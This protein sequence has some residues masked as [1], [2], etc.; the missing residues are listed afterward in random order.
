MYK[1]D[2]LLIMFSCLNIDM[3]FNERYNY[4]EENF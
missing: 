1:Y 3:V 4:V 2:Y